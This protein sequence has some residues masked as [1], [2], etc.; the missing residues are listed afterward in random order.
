MRKL[1]T[2]IYV[3]GYVHNM[4]DRNILESLDNLFCQV[5]LRCYRLLIN[6]ILNNLT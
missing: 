4:S 5:V 3:Y 6:N 1:E 2:S